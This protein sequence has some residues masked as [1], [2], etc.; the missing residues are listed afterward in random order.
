MLM[1]KDT[2]DK[3]PYWLENLKKAISY[4]NSKEFL[5]DLESGKFETDKK[6][7]IYLNLED[8]TVSTAPIFGVTLKTVKLSFWNVQKLGQNNYSIQNGIEVTLERFNKF[9]SDL[10]SELTPTLKPKPHNSIASGEYPFCLFDE[11]YQKKAWDR[12]MVE[13][14]NRDF[15]YFG[16]DEIF[17]RKEFSFKNILPKE[18]RDLFFEAFY[19]DDHRQL[20]S[21]M[22][23]YKQYN[24]ISKEASIAMLDKFKEKIIHQN[25]DINPEN[26]Y[27]CH[28]LFPSVDNKARKQWF[29][30]FYAHLI[31]PSR[32]V[33]KTFGV[34]YPQELDDI[35]MSNTKLI[36][37][38]FDINSLFVGSFVG[39]MLEYVPEEK[40]SSFEVTVVLDS[41]TPTM[42]VSWDEKFKFSPSVYYFD[43]DIPESDTF[44]DVPVEMAFDL[45]SKF[46][47]VKFRL[48]DDACESSIWPELTSKLIDFWV[49]YSKKNNPKFD[50]K[51]DDDEFIEYLKFGENDPK[52][53]IYFNKKM[54][55]DYFTSKKGLFRFEDLQEYYESL[56][57]KLS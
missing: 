11:V 40:L 56:T 18:V 19:C 49:Y 20:T 4:V 46:K 51:V 24:E 33:Y 12:I 25:K 53:F 36:L 13:L 32:K 44:F 35:M 5:N 8:G 37:E 34:D 7:I 54:N 9:I 27:S 52:K 50:F 28:P 43:G 1:V 2:N 14:F 39:E 41:S 38:R 6:S 21:R 3:R 22:F 30:S 23:L 42:L 16:F 26:K 45:L 10:I 29:N 17:D 55:G 47:S 57:K 31:L 48:G 15:D